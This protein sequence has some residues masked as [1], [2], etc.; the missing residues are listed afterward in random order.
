MCRGVCTCAVFR[1][2]RP[3]SRCI[4]K[5][6]NLRVW[7]A[8]YHA[9]GLFKEAGRSRLGTAARPF[10]DTL[11]GKRATMTSSVFIGRCL[12]RPGS[13]AYYICE[14]IRH[15]VDVAAFCSAACPS[16]TSMQKR[17][18]SALSGSEAKQ[19]QRPAAPTHRRD[20][21]HARLQRVGGPLT[22]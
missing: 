12:T 5:S 8:Y 13:C 3:D 17:K 6:S 15:D 14:L 18:S 1:H 20:G 9:P 7:H 2:I 16:T 4:I 11:S 19:Q 22:Q 21:P 10:M